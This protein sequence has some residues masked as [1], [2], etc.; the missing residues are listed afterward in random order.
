MITKLTILGNSLKLCPKSSVDILP[1][2]RC[3]CKPATAAA[4]SYVWCWVGEIGGWKRAAVR[5]R[6]CQSSVDVSSG[7]MLL[8]LLVVRQSSSET[9]AASDWLRR[10]R[11]GGEP[12]SYQDVQGNRGP[13]QAVF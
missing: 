2:I 9:A 10:G 12:T 3:A 1:A 7:T 13:I 4:A 8:S 5:C 6:P 11:P